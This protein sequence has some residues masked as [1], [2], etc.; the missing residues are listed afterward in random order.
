MEMK[1]DRFYNGFFG[2]RLEGENNEEKNDNT[3]S[4]KL[5]CIKDKNG[6][7]I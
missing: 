2:E 7:M 5:K 6:S 3:D 1:D 4:N